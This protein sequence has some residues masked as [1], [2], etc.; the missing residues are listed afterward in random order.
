[1]EFLDKALEFLASVSGPSIATVAIVLEFAFRLVK[2][3][4]PRSILIMAADIMGAAGKVLSK[5]SE[6]LGKVIPQRLK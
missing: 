6:I 4:K 2:T 1:M 3:E 5:A